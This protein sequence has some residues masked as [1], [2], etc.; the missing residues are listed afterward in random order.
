MSPTDLVRRMF[1]RDDGSPVPVKDD[2]LI[3]AGRPNNVVKPC[4]RSKVDG[5]LVRIDLTCREKPPRLFSGFRTDRG[6]L[7]LNEVVIVLVFMAG[8]NFNAKANCFKDADDINQTCESLN[9]AR[10]F[11]PLTKSDSGLGQ[12]PT[13]GLHIGDD[14]LQHCGAWGG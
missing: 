9:Q 2:R 12:K 4:P 1:E 13:R 8:W 7:M 10:Y 5:I 6:C 11:V 3:I 14:S